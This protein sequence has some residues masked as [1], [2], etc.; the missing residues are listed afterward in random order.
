MRAYIEVGIAETGFDA[1]TS[2]ELK[3][4]KAWSLI[5]DGVDAGFTPEAIVLGL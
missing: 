3:R 4:R 2:F 5:D 1:I